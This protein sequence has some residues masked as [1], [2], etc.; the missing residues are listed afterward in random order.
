MGEPGDVN[1]D[2][3]IDL[4]DAGASIKILSGLGQD[5]V[6]PSADVNG[7]GKIGLPEG[8]FVLQTV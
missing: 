3:Q 1:K 8:I 4:K 7:G 2:T 5:G 6:D